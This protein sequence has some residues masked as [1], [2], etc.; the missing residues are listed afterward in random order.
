MMAVLPAP[1]SPTTIVS[2]WR[3]M[4]IVT[5]CSIEGESIATS[6]EK[7]ASLN[8]TAVSPFPSSLYGFTVYLVF[9]LDVVKARG[10]GGGK[11]QIYSFDAI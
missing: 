5:L 10:G 8:S 3:G 2:L 1:T 6:Q 11:Y 4:L 9:T 7:V